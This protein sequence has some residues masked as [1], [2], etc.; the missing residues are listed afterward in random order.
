VTSFS[1]FFRKAAVQIPPSL[2]QRIAMLDTGSSDFILGTALGTDQEAIRLAAIQRLPDGEGLRGLAGLSTVPGVPGAAP[3]SVERAARARMAELVE[4]GSVDFATLCTRPGNYAA[5]LAVAAQCAAPDRMRQ[6]LASIH[7]PAHIARL[8]VEGDSSRIRQAAAEGVQDPAQLRQLMKQVRDRDKSVYKILKQKCDA[9][10]AKERKEAE[11]ADEITATCVSLELHTHRTYDAH[12]GSALEQLKAR[13]SSLAGRAAPEL[14]VRAMEAVDRCHEVI[15]AHVRLA[16]QLAAQQEADRA[17]SQAAEDARER[18]RQAAREA[19]SAQAEAE[20]KIRREAADLREA[21]EA[22]R[23]KILEAQESI[24]RQIGGLVRRA[25]GALETGNTQHAAGLRRAIEQKLPNAPALPVHLVRSLQQLDDKLIELKQWKDYAVAPKRVELIE[26][27]ETLIGS[28]DEPRILADRIKSLQEEWRTIG[29]GI[30]SDAPEEWERFHRASQAAYQPCREYFEAQS[31]L[32]LENLEHR[33]RIVERLTAFE[34]SQN[35]EHPDWRLL[36]S[37]LREA[38]L[39]WRRHHPVEREAG[40][41]IQ[42][43]F[44]AAMGRLQAR[45]GA[46]HERN[47]ADKQALIKRAR[48]LLVQEDGREAVEALKRLQ[49]AWKETGQ[50]PRDQEQAL[51]NEFRELCDAVF[52]RRQQAYA[53]HAAGLEASKA[54]ALGL[55]DEVDRAAEFTGPALIEVAGKIP[56]WRAAFDALDELPR[57]EAQSLKVRFE[58]AVDLCLMRIA[59]KHA[60]D[61]NMAFTNLLEAGRHVSVFEW[62]SMQAVEPAARETFK[63]AALAFIES[64]PRWPRGGLQTVKD[65]LAKAES[66]PG[67]DADDRERALRILCIRSEIECDISSPV[68]DDALRREYQVQRLMRQMGQGIHSSDG[69]WEARGL[70]WIRIGAISPLVHSALQERLLRCWSMRRAD[71]AQPSVRYHGSSADREGSA[72][73]EGSATRAGQG[74]RSVRDRSKFSPGR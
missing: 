18:E 68:E 65:A 70:E 14:A 25:K 71:T 60:R 24:F 13:W 31:K 55:C 1:R 73:R 40:R 28:T 30:A 49:S 17:A 15:V 6:A 46:W 59:E 4:S 19:A 16:A 32:R 47:V 62:A 56:E 67:A 53:D 72:N 23:A 43:D 74:R 64:V 54:K 22:A 3:A 10:S 39:E 29:R 61:A 21:E 5:L 57:A 27:M 66:A 12:Y 41:T 38:P 51:W 20:A 2:D 9:L 8:V 63:Q 7:D 44:D 69:D 45:L 26:E 37:V 52:Q 36:A 42:Q 11:I 58:R 33:R 48:H 35:A 50:A 34:S